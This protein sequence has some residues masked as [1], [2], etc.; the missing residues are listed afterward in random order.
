MDETTVAAAGLTGWRTRIADSVAGPVAERS[1][2]SE[3]QVRA[4]L[5][6]VFLALSLAYVLGAIRRAARH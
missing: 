2:L 1:P 6:L 5:A 3:Q 4:G